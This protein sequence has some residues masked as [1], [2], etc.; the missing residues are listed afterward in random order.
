MSTQRQ[1]KFPKV[2]C[3]WPCA[4]QCKL[5]S[6]YHTCIRSTVLGPP[7]SHVLSLHRG[8]ALWGAARLL[9]R[10]L[11]VKLKILLQVGQSWLSQSS[12]RLQSTCFTFSP[13]QLNTMWLLSS[14]FGKSQ[15][16]VSHDFSLSSPPGLSSQTWVACSSKLLARQRIRA[17][18]TYW[19]IPLNAVD[20]TDQYQQHPVKPLKS[21]DLKWLVVEHFVWPKKKTLKFPLEPT[22]SATVVQKV[23]LPGIQIPAF[24]AWLCHCIQ[25]VQWVIQTWF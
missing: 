5:S 24:T 10:D 16:S 20:M 2:K 17:H 8:R 15:G 13:D 6:G 4:C 21:T 18:Q 14:I 11:P 25:K 3:R 22:A 23:I 9:E 7:T 19:A 1:L 12:G